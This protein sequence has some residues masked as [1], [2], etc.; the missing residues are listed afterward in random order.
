MSC[1][2]SGHDKG[3]VVESLIDKMLFQLFYKVVVYVLALK[4]IHYHF[5]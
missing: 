5:N 2:L 4:I 3:F 1:V